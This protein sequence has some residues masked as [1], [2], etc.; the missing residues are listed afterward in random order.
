[1]AARI[2]IIALSV[3]VTL[4][5]PAI[6]AVNGIRLVTNDRY[7]EAV[8]DYGGVPDDR[9]GLAAADRERLALVGLR[10]IEPSTAEGIG[11][12]REARLA[13]G[14]PAFNAR[15]LA[16]MEDVRT[17]VSRAYRFQIIA[18]IALGIL[19]LLLG[20]L[21]TTR[22]VVPVALVRGAV[23]TVVV[24]VVVGI[25]AATSY[26]SFETPFHSLFF[27][28]ETWRFEETDT[29]RRLYPDRFWLDTAVVIGALAVLQAA[30]LFLLAK[31]WARRAGVRRPLS[32]RPR[33]EST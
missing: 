23:L 20:L 22:A 15:E 17:A 2:A 28:G 16:H 1:V 31:F 21:S 11:L 8:Y 26:G 29:L 6:L 30:G 25:V 10:S 24:A 12:L 5:V 14:E 4:A 18:V 3:A 7:V 19:A 27:E 9:Y 13:N 32:M 33:T